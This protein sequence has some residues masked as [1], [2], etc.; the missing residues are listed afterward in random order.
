MGLRELEAASG[1]AIPLTEEELDALQD[2]DAPLIILLAASPV[3]SLHLLFCWDEPEAE[4]LHRQ[5][6]MHGTGN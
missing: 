2:G 1:G 6:L 4:R 5:R 3:S